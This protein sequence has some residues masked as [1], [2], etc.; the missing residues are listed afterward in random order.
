MQP[1][2]AESSEKRDLYSGFGNALSQAFEFAAVVLLAW[3]GGRWIGGSAGGALGLVF[4]WVGA[5]LRAYYRYMAAADANDPLK[6]LAG[7]QT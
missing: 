7:E 6:R 5:S 4:G 2:P 3:A 1:T